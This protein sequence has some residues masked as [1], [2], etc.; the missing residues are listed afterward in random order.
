MG[1]SRCDQGGRGPGDP[2]TVPVGLELE[3]QAVADP[4][5]GRRDDVELEWS[6]GFVRRARISAKHAS[7]LAAALVL[8]GHE[9][10]QFLEELE[11][12]TRAEHHADVLAWLERA[13]RPRTLRRL[14]LGP[15]A[16]ALPDSLRAVF[17][18]LS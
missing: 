12:D 10:G 16:V 13:R 15:D 8:L 2:L 18:N 9:A 5:Q 6:R 3:A 1:P 7:D 4:E 14:T 17:P 11:I